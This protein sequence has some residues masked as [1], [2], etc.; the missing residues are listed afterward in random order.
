MKLSGKNFPRNFI[1]KSR[2]KTNLSVDI[3]RKTP[4]YQFDFCYHR[5]KNI[6]YHEK[7]TLCKTSAPFQQTN[8]SDLTNEKKVDYQYVYR[9]WIVKLFNRKHDSILFRSKKSLFDSHLIDEIASQFLNMRARSV[10]YVS[11][12]SQLEAV[13]SKTLTIAWVIHTK[14]THT[15][16]NEL[17]KPKDKR[18]A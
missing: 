10:F 4:I 1:S 15:L 7:L 11:V 16:S 6:V 14:K 8:L 18:N 17:D 9:S 12:L 2:T 5:V 13:L 3:L